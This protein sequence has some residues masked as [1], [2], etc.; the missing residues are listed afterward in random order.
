MAKFHITVTGDAAPC[1]ATQKACPRGGADDHYATAD[2][3][4]R[5]AEER[6][7]NEFFAASVAYAKHYEEHEALMKALVNG[8][9]D[10]LAR[11]ES[12]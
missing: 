10:D 3:A 7:N 11:E 9:A 5:A 2:D 1:T 4:R 12:A 8:E 6:L